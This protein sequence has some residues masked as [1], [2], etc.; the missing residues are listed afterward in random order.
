MGNRFTIHGTRGTMPVAGRRFEGHGTQTTC[1]SLRTP[2]GLIVVDAGTGIIALSDRL[3][4]EAELPPITLLFTHFHLDHVI[5]LPLFQPLYR[6]RTR[7]TLMADPARPGGWKR[8]LAALVGPP[9]WPV[10]LRHCG[11]RIRLEDLPAGRPA[12]RRHGVRIAWCPL[13]HPQQCL[14]YRL[15][16]NGRSV[17]IATDHEPGDPGVDRGFLRFCR[18]ADVLISDAQYTPDQQAARRGWGH[19]AWTDAAAIARD[20][21]V[22]ELILTHHDRGRT[23]AQ[24]EAIVRQARR[25][26]PRTRAARE[27]LTLIWP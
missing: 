27:G 15:E 16:T 7:I 18:G 14:A 8:A 12:M 3:R 2:R 23:D 19:G 17:V 26:F 1:F 11:A 20:A 21:G 9:F 6:P 25:H 5:G 4:R 10:R 13:R 24:I 22:G